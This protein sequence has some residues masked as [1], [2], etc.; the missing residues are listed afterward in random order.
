MNRLQTDNAPSLSVVIPPFIFGALSFFALSVLIIL[1][2]TDL[3]GP[4]F[5]GRILAITHLAVLGWGTMIIFGALYQL[6]PV[7]FEVALFS[8]KLAKTTTGLFALSI[9]LLAYSFWTDAFST[10][11]LYTASLMFIALLLFIINILV[12][13]KNGKR[14]IQSRFIAAAVYWLF[15]TALLGWLISLNFRY[16]FFS[17]VHLHY[18]KIHAHLG[19]VGWFILLIIG[20]SSTLL[21]MFFISHKLNEKKLVAAFYLINGG[22]GLLVLDWFFLTGT[23]LVYLYW[24]IIAAGLFFYFAYIAESYKKR[25]RKELD[26]GMK[27]TVVSIVILLVPIFVSLLVL[28]GSIFEYTFLQR[29]A[30]FYGFSLIFGLITSIILGQTLKTLPFIIWLHKYKQFVGKFKTPMPKDL[31]SEKIGRLQLIT[32]FTAII[33]LT[34]ALLLNNSGLLMLGSYALFFAAFLYNINVFKIIFHKTK[35]EKL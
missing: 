12:S 16:N 15:L 28:Q 23:F 26:I 31:Y 29:L 33:I 11:L 32:Y 4:Y 14:N 13:K 35:T 2:G 9:I 30:T 17:Q 27:F 1:A 34:A 25:L 24:L 10:L 5:N 22:L 21:P 18:L 19:F 7:V 8:E 3:L 6:I 20:V